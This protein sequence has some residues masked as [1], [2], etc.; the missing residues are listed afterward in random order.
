M[1]DCSTV[2][3]LDLSSDIAT[4]SES[5]TC[6]PPSLRR[7]IDRHESLRGPGAGATEEETR[8]SRASVIRSGLFLARTGTR[9]SLSS[10]IAGNWVVAVVAAVAAVVVVKFAGASR[11]RT[12]SGSER[13]APPSRLPT[14]PTAVCCRVAVTM[15]GFDLPT[16]TRFEPDLRNFQPLF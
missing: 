8:T 13:A 10:I 16:V 3:S 2:P 1:I 4:L 15:T 5:D 7:A 12:N 14:I 11:A 6:D 9:Q